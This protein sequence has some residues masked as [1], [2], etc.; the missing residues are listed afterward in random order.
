[1]STGV[2]ESCPTTLA[3]INCETLNLIND[4]VFLFFQS[5]GIACNQFVLFYIRVLVVV[6]CGGPKKSPR[7]SI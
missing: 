5:S 4:I 7:T 2:T 6:P 1:M 3:L